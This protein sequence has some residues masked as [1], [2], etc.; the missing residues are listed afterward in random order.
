M[1][2]SFSKFTVFFQFIKVSILEKKVL[3]AAAGPQLYIEH[4]EYFLW[5]QQGGFPCVYQ[6]PCQLHS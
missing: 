1:I 2:K 4:I 6:P 5:V 3:I